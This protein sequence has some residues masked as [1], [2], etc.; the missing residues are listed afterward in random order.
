MKNLIESENEIMKELTYRK[1]GDYYIPDIKFNNENYKPL[2]KYGRMRKSW[3]MEHHSP[4]FNHLLLS[5]KL[6]PHLNEV[7]EQAQALLNEMMPKYIE[8]FG[9]TAELKRTDQI[10]WVRL[11]NM[12]HSI[13]D[14][15][16]FRNIVYK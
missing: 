15:F 9:I 1:N 7:N 6:V 12:A 16:I 11:M 14:E 10:E 8:H 13:C 2:G 3:L 4:L 5:E